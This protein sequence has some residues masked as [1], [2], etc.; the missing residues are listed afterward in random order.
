MTLPSPARPPERSATND[1]WRGLA[2]LAVVA[3]PFNGQPL[4]SLRFSEPLHWLSN[5]AL[6]TAWPGHTGVLTVSRNVDYEIGFYLLV[7]LALLSP[8]AGSRG[9]LAFHA[10]VE[11]RA[12]RLRS[13]PAP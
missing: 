7:G 3:L 4:S 2:C 5:L 12:D 6:T 13:R 8:G 11:R 9:R 1:V 10:L